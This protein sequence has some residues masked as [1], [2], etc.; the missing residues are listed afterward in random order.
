MLTTE[1]INGRLS[2]TPIDCSRKFTRSS[3]TSSGPFASDGG[4][5]VVPYAG[6]DSCGAASKP[7]VGTV[8]AK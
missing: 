8:A 1:N 6:G 2:N 5:K 3:E 4:V 7:K